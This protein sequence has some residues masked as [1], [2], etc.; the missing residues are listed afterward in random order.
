MVRINCSC[1]TLIFFFSFTNLFLHVILMSVKSTALAL[2]HR[3]L[4]LPIYRSNC[5]ADLKRCI[6]TTVVV[7]SYFTW[8]TFYLLTL[9]KSLLNTHCILYLNSPNTA[10]LFMGELTLNDWPIDRLFV[11]LFF[12][13]GQNSSSSSTSHQGPPPSTPHCS[14][15]APV[16]TTL[17]LGLPSTPLLTRTIAQRHRRARERTHRSLTL[18][19]IVHPALPL[20]RTHPT[21]VLNRCK[22]RKTGHTD[23]QRNTEV[24]FLPF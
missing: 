7:L 12:R 3:N 24:C 2:G 16:K 22:R 15:L 13:T 23:M 9:F 14:L 8:L 5:L 19:R 20:H 1:C 4:S 11:L 21:S 17:P 18:Q 6:L 10:W